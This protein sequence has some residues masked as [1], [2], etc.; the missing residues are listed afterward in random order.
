QA[1]AGAVLALQVEPPRPDVLLSGAALPRALPPSRA[2]A[3]PVRLRQQP[4]LRDRLRAGV[5]APGRYGL[6][7]GGGR[8]GG[9]L[10]DG[11]GALQPLRRLEPA[12]ADLSAG[13]AVADD[14]AAGDR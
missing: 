8:A 4:G 9:R 13:A 7:G 6:R 1:A 2:G 11:G 5:A 10:R 14:R 3:E 12:D